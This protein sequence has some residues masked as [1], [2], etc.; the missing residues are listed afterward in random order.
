MPAGE[1]HDHHHRDISGGEARAAVFGMSDGLVSNAALII[2]LAGANTPASAVRVFGF[3][4]L[5]AGA[6]SMASGEYGSVRAQV[7]LYERELDMER[8]EIQHRPEAE[9]HELALIYERRGVDPEIASDLAK[10]MMRDPE[11][12]LETHAREELGIDP[13][14]LGRPLGAAASSFVSFALGA[15]I[16]MLPWF[17]ASGGLALGLTIVLAAA[18]AIGLGFALGMATGRAPLRPV[19]RQL[20]LGA[21]AAGVTYAIGAAFQTTV[22]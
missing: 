15:L 7:E 9:Q 5:V 2:G 6:F 14:A 10:Q 4:G 1:A 12:A 16:P 17:A 11:L 18:S 19:L 8:R 21:A 20:L 13:N 3:I 22:T